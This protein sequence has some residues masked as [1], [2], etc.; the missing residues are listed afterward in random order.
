MKRIR[1]YWLKSFEYKE[2]F[3]TI[4]IKIFS[5]YNCQ[6]HRHFLALQKE[7]ATNQVHRFKLDDLWPTEKRGFNNSS[8]NADL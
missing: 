3:R 5:R 8:Y 1:V 2:F 6:F 4:L 7:K